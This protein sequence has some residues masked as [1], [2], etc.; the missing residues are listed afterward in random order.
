MNVAPPKLPGTAIFVSTRSK[1][2]Y[3]D[4]RAMRTRVTDEKSIPPLEKLIGKMSVC[5]LLSR[6]TH[7]FPKNRIPVPMNALSS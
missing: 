4:T 2:E 5:T 1:N 7:A 3:N 6:Y